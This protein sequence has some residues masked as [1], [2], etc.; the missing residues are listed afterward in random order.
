MSKDMKRGASANIMRIT[1]PDGVSYSLDELLTTSAVMDIFG[2]TNVTVYNWLG[3]VD[4]NGAYT[5]GKFRHAFKL[6]GNIYIP[7][8]DVKNVIK[9][10][11]TK[12]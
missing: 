12:L 7:V 5:Q 8:E 11:Q 4:E 2:V 1:A 9:Q 6:G 3:K 10:K